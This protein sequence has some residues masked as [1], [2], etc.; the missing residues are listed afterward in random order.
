MIELLSM[1]QKKFAKEINLNLLKEKTPDEYK[2][3]LQ[4]KKEI[5][6]LMEKADVLA[7]KLRKNILD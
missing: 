1:Y 5:F 6:D 4:V 2:E 7:D 3:F